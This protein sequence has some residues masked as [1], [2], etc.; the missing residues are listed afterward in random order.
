METKINWQ[1]KQFVASSVI[2]ANNKSSGA[3]SS[4]RLYICVVMFGVQEEKN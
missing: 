4:F 1:G 3:G 2:R